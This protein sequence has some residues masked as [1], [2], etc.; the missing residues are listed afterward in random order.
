VVGEPL[1]LVETALQSQHLSPSQEVWNI[2][3]FLLRDLTIFPID[4]IEERMDG[5][6]PMKRHD[7]P[8]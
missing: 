1:A 6:D 4:E 8:R 2:S 5:L 3:S 7:E